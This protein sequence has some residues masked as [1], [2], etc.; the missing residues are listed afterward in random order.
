MKFDLMII[1]R[2]NGH[3]LS[4]VDV[5]GGYNNAENAFS[6]LCRD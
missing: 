1:P 4:V 5:K 2:I 6:E 3:G